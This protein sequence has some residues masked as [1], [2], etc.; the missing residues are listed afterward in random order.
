[1]RMPQ[2]WTIVNHLH[3]G[4]SITSMQAPMEKVNNHE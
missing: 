1:M 3:S 4:K 2:W